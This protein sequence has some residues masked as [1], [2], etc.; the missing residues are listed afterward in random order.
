MGLV[1]LFAWLGMENAQAVDATTLTVQLA[2]AALLAA[3]GWFL[4]RGLGRLYRL[5]RP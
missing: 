5:R 2:G 4:V 1:Q 3:V